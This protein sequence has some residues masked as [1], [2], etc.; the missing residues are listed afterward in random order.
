MTAHLF[1]TGASG[2]LGGALV[3][4]WQE[5]GRHVEVFVREG[6]RTDL[7]DE[8]SARVHRGDLREADA[9]RRAIRLAA[10]EAERAGAPLEVVHAGALIS[11]RTADAEES[12]ASNVQGTRHVVEASAQCGARRLLLV[13]SVVAVGVAPS[14]EEALD[15]EAEFNGAA[16]A[17]PYVTTKRAAE[18]FA[19]AATAHHE[20]EVVVVNPGAIYGPSPRISNTTRFLLAVR[21]GGLG[22]LLPPGS[23]GVVGL[24]DVVS[25]C[26]AALE[27]GRDGRRYILSESNWL[28]SEVVALARE[29]W[30]LPERRLRTCPRAL[31]RVAVAAVGIVDRLRA[32]DGL[33]PQAM[34]LLGHHFRFDASRAREELNW[35]PTPFTD[36]LRRT[37][38]R[39]RDDADADVDASR[40][41]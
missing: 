24:E 7:F 9:V 15:E 14:P 16:L 35:K 38:D 6:S 5:A 19:L 40:A 29:A 33:T 25:G 31:W 21:D 17:C 3:R 27:R 12:R 39:L 34:R 2:T 26:V 28:I 18:D 30:G 37:V 4:R 20:L 8:A 36:V 10:Q 22:P 32:L 11:Y 41:P 1:V 13:S 23:M